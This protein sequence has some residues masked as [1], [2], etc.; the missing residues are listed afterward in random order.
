M[1]KEKT[2]TMNLKFTVSYAVS[3]AR[4]KKALEKHMNSSHEGHKS[5]EVCGKH[6]LSAE[7]LKNHAKNIQNVYCA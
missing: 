5:C 2:L 4:I 1:L 6:L 3:V 7:A